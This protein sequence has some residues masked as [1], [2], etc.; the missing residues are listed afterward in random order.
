MKEAVTI[1]P[2]QSAARVRGLRWLVP[3]LADFLFGAFL[4]WLF[5]TGEGWKSLLGDGDCGWHI[6]TGDYI[7]AQGHVPRVDI[8]SY[9]KPGQPWFAWEWLSDVTFS[10]LHQ[11][12][13]LKGVVLL[14][15]V[16]LAA[17]ATILFQH[18]LW[19]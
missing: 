11:D 18:T 8:F 17:T 4:I 13:G 7:L 2:V 10:A 19:S 14:A 9:T 16:V 12:L 5:V 6:R 15:G 3:S 1:L